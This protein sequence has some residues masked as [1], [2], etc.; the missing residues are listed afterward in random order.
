[1]HSIQHTTHLEAD[2]YGNRFEVDNPDE[3]VFF[4]SL[5][6]HATA[7]DIDDTV[8]LLQKLSDEQPHFGVQCVLKSLIDMFQARSYSFKMEDYISR[9]R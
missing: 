5:P 4:A 3:I 2:E 6:R 7:T 8:K 9:I 1:M